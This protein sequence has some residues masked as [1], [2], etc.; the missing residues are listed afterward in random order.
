M[1]P[2]EEKGVGEEHLQ[3]YEGIGSDLIALLSPACLDLGDQGFDRGQMIVPR[4]Q[5]VFADETKGG[6]EGRGI[7]EGEAFV[8]P[9][10]AEILGPVECRDDIGAAD[11]IVPAIHRPLCSDRTD[12]GF[13]DAPGRIDR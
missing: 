8:D 13:K 1:R 5:A 3:V 9:G 12:P 6:Q 4:V 11:L 7:G 10:R 2:A